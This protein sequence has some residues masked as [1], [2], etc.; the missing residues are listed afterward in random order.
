[1]FV[2]LNK[3]NLKK[4]IFVNKMHKKEVVHMVFDENNPCQE[5]SDKDLAKAIVSAFPFYLEMSETK[6]EV[7]AAPKVEEVKEE[8]KEPEVEPEV[9]PEPVKEE[10]KELETEE[11]QED[12]FELRNPLI[13]S[14]FV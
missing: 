6:P 3:E 4:K 14:I 13:L 7:K 11:P 5:V 10:T 1:M 9:E 12:A 8:V 2:Y